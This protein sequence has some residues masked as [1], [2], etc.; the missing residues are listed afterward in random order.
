ME[1]VVDVPCSNPDCPQVGIKGG[2]NVF[3]R[4]RYGPEHIRFL[5][6]TAC[7][8]EFS[9]R[10]GTAFWNLKLPKATIIQVTKHLAEGTGVRKT[11]RLTGV[12]RQTVGRVLR[13]V[14]GHAKAIHDQLVQGVSVVEVQFDEMWSFVK[15][16]TKT[17]RTQ[18][19]PPA[20]SAAS[21]TTRPSTRGRS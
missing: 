7:K 3:V 12:G 18:T 10:Q 19:K 20:R 21:G 8:R 4:R 17:S 2:G 16:R 13:A 15:K 14:G 1:I 11:H 5:R 6:C 9:E